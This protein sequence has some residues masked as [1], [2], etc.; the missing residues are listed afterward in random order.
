MVASCFSVFDGLLW[1]GL[2]GVFHI[3]AV[4]TCVSS[5]SVFVFPLL[6]CG[7]VVFLPWGSGTR[8]WLV[9]TVLEFGQMFTV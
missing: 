8:F 5:I 7:G 6:E 1:E 3:E 2:L 9:P 4:A